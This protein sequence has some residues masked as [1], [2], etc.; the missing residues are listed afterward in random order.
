[1]LAGIFIVGGIDALRNPIERGKTAEHVV[2]P[3]GERLRDTSLPDERE[4]L[5][6][7]N[8]GVQIVGGVMLATNIFSRTAAL[9]LTASLVPTTLG[10]HAFWKVQG[11]ERAMQMT[12]F[13]KNLAIGGGLLTS[14]LDTGGRPSVFWS[15]RR[16]ASRA[17]DAVSDRTG[18]ISQTL[19]NR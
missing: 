12:Q 18:R 15:T 6:K 2:D 3:V 4:S 8:A 14:A 17:A 10:G 11:D 19:P 5:V 1:M 7:L 9:A 16:A 13:L